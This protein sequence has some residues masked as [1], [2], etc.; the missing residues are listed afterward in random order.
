MLG[1]VVLLFAVV[2]TTVEAFIPNAFN[3]YSV[4]SRLSMSIEDRTDLRNV[5]IIGKLKVIIIIKCSQQ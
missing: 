1:K 4:K 5:A 3:R 2:A